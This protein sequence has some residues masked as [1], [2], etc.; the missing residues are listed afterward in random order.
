LSSDHCFSH[1]WFE[2][3]R[4]ILFAGGLR[5]ISDVLLWMGL[6]IYVVHEIHVS[7]HMEEIV[8]F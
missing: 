1:I 8:G 3:N 5:D 6:R 7:D 2:E 4:A